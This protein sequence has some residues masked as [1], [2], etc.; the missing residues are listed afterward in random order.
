MVSL[1]DELQKLFIEIGTYWVQTRVYASFEI[2][3][4]ADRKNPGVTSLYNLRLT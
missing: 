2:A 3:I 1:T 4:R